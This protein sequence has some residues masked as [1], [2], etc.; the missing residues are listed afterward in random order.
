MGERTKTGLID[1]PEGKKSYKDMI[2]EF[3]EDIFTGAVED[4]DLSDESD[5]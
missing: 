2:E 4:V 1:T 3:P 5:S